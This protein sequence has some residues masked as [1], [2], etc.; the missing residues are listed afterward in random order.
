MT[1][2]FWVDGWV[3]GW[4]QEEMGK[5]RGHR[6]LRGY[7]PSSF[8]PSVFLMVGCSVPALI[9]LT[10]GLHYLR[11]SFIQHFLSTCH[12]LGAVIGTRDKD[13]NMTRSLF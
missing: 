7:T 3:N 1:C 2:V 13:K 12:M 10:M 5:P 6:T 8:P 9:F 11:T 4:A